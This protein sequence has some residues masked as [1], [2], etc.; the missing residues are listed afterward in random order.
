MYEI[1]EDSTPKE[2]INFLRGASVPEVVAVC[3]IVRKISDY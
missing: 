2:Q 3:V 1:S